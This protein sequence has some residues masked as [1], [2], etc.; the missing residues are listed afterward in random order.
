[1]GNPVLRQRAEPVPNPLAPE[2]RELVADMIETMEEA[3][4]IGLAAPQI[5]VS[6]RVMVFYAPGEE[7]APEGRE[8]W[9]E[10]PDADEIH[11]NPVT[12]L[13]NPEVEALSDDRDLGWEGCLSVPG[14]LGLVPR[15]TRIRYS[16][17]SPEGR[18]V[19]RV[20]SGFHARVFQHE[21]D[22]LDGILYPQRMAD[23]SMLIF[24]SQAHHYAA[25][26]PE[27]E[28]V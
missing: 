10:R 24:E 5:G 16:G 7:P 9:E 22:H 15:F 25:A 11:A 26:R 1:M 19:E 2:V 18:L 27:E 3:S 14:L 12:I 20:A 13:I 6:S 4:G 28:P 17:I 21:F 8:E 23:P